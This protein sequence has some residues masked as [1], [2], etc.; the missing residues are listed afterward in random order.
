MAKVFRSLERDISFLKINKV[1]QEPSGREVDKLDYEGS[2]SD[3][4]E[5]LTDDHV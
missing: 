3:E 5:M 2:S 4:D 1:P